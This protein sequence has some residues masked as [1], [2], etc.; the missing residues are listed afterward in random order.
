MV[1]LLQQM[2]RGRTVQTKVLLVSKVS[3]VNMSC[4]KMFEGKNRRIEL[5]RE[6]QTTHAL[7]VYAVFKVTLF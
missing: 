5:I 1:I 3:L 4:F 6:L 7:Q 2:L